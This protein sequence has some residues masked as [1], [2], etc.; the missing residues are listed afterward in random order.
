MKK[1]ERSEL[2]EL[3]AYEQIRERFLQRM[4]AEKKRRRVAIGDHVTALFENRDSVL[5]QIQ[6]MLRTE[7]ITQE[8]A[9]AH[10]LDTYNELVPGDHELSITYFIEYPEREE[11]ERMLVE[12]AGIEQ[13]FWLEAGGERLPAQGPV[14]GDDPGRT[15]TLHYMKIPLSPAAEQAIAERRGPVKLGVSHPKYGA[16]VELS[17]ETLGAIA[18]EL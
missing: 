15:T 7:R 14:R 1:V 8:A 9:I 12:L 16:E 11:R 10:E 18:G 6:E 3:G 2:L 17:A 13:A 5:F 4:I